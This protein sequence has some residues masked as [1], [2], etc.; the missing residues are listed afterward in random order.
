MS[1]GR[2]LSAGI[3]IDGDELQ[4]D[5]SATDTVLDVEH[6]LDFLE[7]DYGETI[8]V[9]IIAEDGTEE[10]ATIKVPETEDEDTVDDEEGFITL[11]A[12]LVNAYPAGT[13]VEVY[14]ETKRLVAQV[15]LDDAEEDSET[16][17]AV[18]HHSLEDYVPEGVDLDI[19]VEMDYDGETYYV[20]N[21]RGEHLPIELIG[22]TITGGIVR[23]AATGERVELNANTGFLEF[24][25]ADESTVGFFDGGGEALDPFPTGYMAIH[26]NVTL[27]LDCIADVLVT[28][29]G[30]L[31]VGDTADESGNALL[32]RNVT[33]D[34]DIPTPPSGYVAIFWNSAAA[35]IKGKSSSGVVRKLNDIDF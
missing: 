25:G 1:Y 22:P 3:E 20:T 29:P 32:I 27:W 33:N 31:V 21:V 30:G 28:A 4:S 15:R 16:I 5:H 11:S 12:G 24:I 17:D 10:L 13:R 26:A 14:P 2:I 23:T 6:A 19:A 8:Q 7:P 34:A 35:Q 9:R 18:V